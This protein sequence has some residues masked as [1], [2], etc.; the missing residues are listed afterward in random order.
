MSAL[1]ASSRP[2]LRPSSALRHMTRSAAR[3][4]ESTAAGK[5]TEAASKTTDA[6]KGAASKAAQGLSRVTSAAGPAIASAA[7]GVSGALG[8]VG[9]RT[10]RLIAFVERQTPFVVY[11]SKVG[12]ELAKLVFKGQKMTPPSL[13]TFQAYFQGIWKSLQNPGALLQSASGLVSQP[14]SLLQRARSIN[15]TQIV[16]GGVLLA[17]CLGFFTVGEMVGRMKLIGYHGQTEAHH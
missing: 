3:R 4:Y 5:A 1:A 8:K 17:E 13:S 15:R 9:G 7:K 14:A 12:A 2:F 10:G 6:A 16:G 11:Y